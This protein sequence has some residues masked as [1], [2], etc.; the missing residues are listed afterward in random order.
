LLEDEEWKLRV[1]AE[2]AFYLANDYGRAWWINYSTGNSPLPD[3]LITE[4]NLRL[5][6]VDDDFTANYAKAIMGLVNSNGAS[7]K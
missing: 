3:D 1:H 6:Q 7:G 5:S 4:V 2:T